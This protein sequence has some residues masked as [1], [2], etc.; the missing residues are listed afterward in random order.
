VEDKEE[1]KLQEDNQLMLLISIL[2]CPKPKLSLI[3]LIKEE[4]N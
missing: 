4:I 2:L 3:T 1:S